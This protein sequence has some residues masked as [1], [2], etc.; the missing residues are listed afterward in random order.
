STPSLP[1][2]DTVI[3]SGSVL[4][5]SFRWQDLLGVRVRQLVNDCGCKDAILWLSQLLV[6]GTGSAGFTGFTG[7]TGPQFRNRYFRFGH[8]G[9]F[10]KWGGEDFMNRYWVPLLV[11]RLD[12]V[13]DVDERRG[14]LLEGYLQWL[15][16]RTALITLL[17]YALP[18]S[19]VATYL[20]EFAYLKQVDSALELAAIAESLATNPRRRGEAMLVAASSLRS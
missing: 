1:V 7:V 5:H 17:V 20:A 6:I 15:A 3:L 9:F 8:S 13:D 11:D 14:T 2:I 16:P 10:R 12:R 19:V 18:L 4:P